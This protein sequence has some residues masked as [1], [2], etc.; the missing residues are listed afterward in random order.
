MD[1]EL[2]AAQALRVACEAEPFAA[3]IPAFIEARAAEMGDAIAANFFEDGTTLTYAEIAETTRALAAGLQERGIRFG[4][5]VG[6]MLPNIAAFPLTWLALGRLGAIMVPINVRYTPREVAYVLGDSGA[7]LL[8]TDREVL[9]EIAGAPELA[10]F[11]A[12]ENPVVVGGSGAASWAALAKTDAAGFR[13]EREPDLEDLVNIQY[14]S[15][16]TGFPKGCML[17]HRYWLTLA[18]VASLR[19]QGIAKNVLA[20]QPYY[21]M[22][23]QWLTLMAMNLR[24]TV[25]VAGKASATNFLGWIHRYGIEYCIFP[26][27]VLKQPERPEDANLPLKM[28]SVF[29]LRKEMHVAMETRFNVVA[30]ES[31]GMTEVG[32]ALFTPYNV[33]SMVGT[34][35]CGIPSP[36][37]EATIRDEHGNPV[38]DGEIGELWIRGPGILKG[39]WNK[40]EANVDSFREGGWFRTGDLFRRDARGFHY[41]VGRVKD[42]IRRSGENIA[43]REVEAVMLGWPEVLEAAAIGVPDLD[44]GQE[45]KACLILQPEVDPAAFDLAGFLDHCTK[46]LAPFKV[47]RFVEIRIDLPKTPSGKVAKHQIVAERADLRAGAFDRLAGQWLPG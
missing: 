45:V 23:P 18:R 11:E 24:S 36:F 14:T 35:T 31:F 26:Q 39:Y 44:R 4:D 16:T 32:S 2:L 22:D 9:A 42:M 46:N 6:V 40:P 34:G 41:I 3:N 33:T 27:I 10:G 15:G 21:Y 37:R 13:P 7:T 17:T 29:G 5:R 25:F 47:P 38:P 28:A 12:L 8:V 19:A 1:D 43:A 20:A 30:R